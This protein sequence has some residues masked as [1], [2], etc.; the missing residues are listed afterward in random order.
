M[1]MCSPQKAQRWVSQVESGANS[2]SLASV[3]T[4][5]QTK[6]LAVLAEVS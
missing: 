6:Q 2:A 1:E 4:H 3:C 5:N